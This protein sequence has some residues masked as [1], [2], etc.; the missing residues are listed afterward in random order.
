MQAENI[1]TFNLTTEQTIEN[2][3]NNPQIK[4]LNLSGPRFGFSMTLGPDGKSIRRPENQKV[5][6]QLYPYY[7]NLDTNLKLLI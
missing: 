3:L 2:N 6:W 5:E 1:I 4:K 7:P